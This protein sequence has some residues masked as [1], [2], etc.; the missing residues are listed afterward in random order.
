MMLS[1]LDLKLRVDALL[2]EASK[3]V[4]IVNISYA[5]ILEFFQVQ[6]RSYFVLACLLFNKA[7]N[8]VSKGFIIIPCIGLFLVL[9][10]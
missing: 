9:G 2:V 1:I 5:E 4:V 6:L 8:I 10:C 3:E 7:N